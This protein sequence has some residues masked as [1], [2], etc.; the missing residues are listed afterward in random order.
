MDDP[1]R[2]PEELPPRH[3]NQLYVLIIVLLIILISLFVFDNQQ[4]ILSKY[5]TTRT[6]ISTSTETIN[7]ITINKT[8]YKS[9]NRIN[10]T[11]TSETETEVVDRRKPH[12]LKKDREILIESKVNKGD[13]TTVGYWY[14]SAQKEENILGILEFNHETLLIHKFAS[15]FQIELPLVKIAEGDT[16]IYINGKDGLRYQLGQDGTLAVWEGKKLINK[17]AEIPD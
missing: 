14:D 7:G 11:S 1:T 8:E 12:G 15:G 13:F 9:V 4:Y 16:T 10:K 3:N 2:K 6:V 5:L 17:L